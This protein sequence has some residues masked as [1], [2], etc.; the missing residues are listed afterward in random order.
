MMTEQEY[1]QRLN[2]AQ[3]IRP[4]TQTGPQMTFAAFVYI[5]LCGLTALGSACLFWSSPLLLT[6]IL[7]VIGGLMLAV[8][9]S[10][11]DLLLCAFCGAFGAIAEAF[12]IASGAWSYTLP[13]ASGVPLWLP[14][15]WGIAALFI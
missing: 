11:E 12:G 6:G 5:W 9:K 10:A 8:R 14:V 13:L 4:R 3:P 1:P 2:E 7:A 15:M